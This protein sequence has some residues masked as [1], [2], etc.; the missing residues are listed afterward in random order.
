M[1]VSFAHQLE[2]KLKIVVTGTGRSGTGF[3]ARW[4]TSIGIPSGHE[5]FFD[6]HGLDR[7]LRTLAIR[8]FHIVGECSW[9]AAPYLDSAPLCD[10]L[11]VHQ[12][13]HPKKVLESCMRV[14][15]GRTKHY[16]DY[17]VEHLPLIARYRSDL[18]KAACRWIYWNQ[19]IE[20]QTQRR[21]SYFWRVEDGT[22]GLL[23]WLDECGLVDAGRINPAQMFSNTRHNHKHGPH[24]VARLESVHPDLRF[25]LE[26][27]MRR[28]GYQRWD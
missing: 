19:M 10:A 17:L 9:E 6:F 25:A 20:A 13:R 15:P 3:A 12:V 27:Q 23:R 8:D 2:R 28:Y 14:P 1:K 24:Q 4:L 5:M 7:A 26:D 22:D 16:Y 21:E 11:L 18:D